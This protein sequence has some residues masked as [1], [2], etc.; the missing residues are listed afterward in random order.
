MQ[1]H[2]SVSHGIPIISLEEAQRRHRT[3]TAAGMSSELP[4]HLQQQAAASRMDSAEQGS[5][6]DVSRAGRTIS[7]PSSPPPASNADV[8]ADASNRKGRTVYG[9]P[10]IS[11]EEAQRRAGVS[12]STLPSHAASEPL[13]ARPFASSIAPSAITDVSEMAYSYGTSSHRDTT[14]L[15]AGADDDDWDGEPPRISRAF[16]SDDEAMDNQLDAISPKGGSAGGH[17]T[18][19]SLPGTLSPVPKLNPSRGQPFS[20]SV[21]TSSF[22]LL[23]ANHAEMLA[24]AS[25]TTVSSAFHPPRQDYEANAAPVP[26]SHHVADSLHAAGAEN[27][28][29][30]PHWI[31]CTEEPSGHR[32]YVN[33]ETRESQWE[34]PQQV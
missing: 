19:S 15:L 29:L 31:A 24:V 22:L 9:I 7:Q 10:V 8:S 17:A 11:L 18:R 1:R 27:E 25:P 20:P 30:P 26:A 16:A 2:F 3:Q 33:T 14:G 21:D 13:H 4:L 28:V 32:Y 23:H 5:A 6:A 34:R 12:V